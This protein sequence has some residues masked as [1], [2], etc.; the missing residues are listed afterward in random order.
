MKKL[1][2]FA[3]IIFASFSSLSA[4]AIFTSYAFNIEPKEQNTVL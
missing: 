4:Q 3:I 2:L 1:S